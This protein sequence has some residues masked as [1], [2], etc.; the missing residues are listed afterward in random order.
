MARYQ[1]VLIDRPSDWTPDSL[2]DVPPEPGSLGEV[3]AE[4][5]E[6][7]AALR[8]AMEYNRA[9]PAGA[10]SRW[11][12]VVEPGALGCTWRS[13][14]LCTPVRYQVAGI[15]WPLG[16]EPQSPLD[17]PNCVWR[18]QGAAAGENLDYPRAVAVARALNQQSL[19]HG[20]TAWYVVLA[21]ENEPLSQTVSYDAAGLETTVQVRR[22]HV[23][24]PEE[25]PTAGDCSYCPA[26]S[27]E[28]A[29]ADWSTLEQTDRLVR[30][31][32]LGAGD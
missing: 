14:R 28:C 15:W 16:W 1:A 30:Q 7:F 31:R 5:D 9:P 24:R 26:Q 8:V 10:A 25:G 12:V 23:V 11:A 22:L 2:D 4:A 19:D 17:V 18:A 6:L 27:F 21:V 3:L 13:A 32:H 20:A 29:K